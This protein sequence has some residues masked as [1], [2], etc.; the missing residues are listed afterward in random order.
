MDDNSRGCEKEAAEDK[1]ERDQL[2]LEKE[3]A[4]EGRK[5]SELTR[6]ARKVSSGTRIGAIK[7]MVPP[8]VE[9]EDELESDTS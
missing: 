8:T 3:Q 9:I 6:K 1:K 5:G 7:A 2:K 4:K